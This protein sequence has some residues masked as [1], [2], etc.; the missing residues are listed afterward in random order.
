MHPPS[1]GSDARPGGSA[2]RPSR[3]RRLLVR[4]AVI[5]LIANLILLL[6]LPLLDD[7]LPTRNV[8][9][10]VFTVVAAGKALFDTLFFD[11]YRP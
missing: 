8:A 6:P 1:V 3:W 5:G 10:A 2:A 7:W 4:L 9:A 11:R